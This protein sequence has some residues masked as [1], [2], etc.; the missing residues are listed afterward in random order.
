[1]HFKTLFTLGT[2]ASLAVAA[3][4]STE[5]MTGSNGENTTLV[6]RGDYG[7]GGVVA[8]SQCSGVPGSGGGCMSPFSSNLS[9]KHS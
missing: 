5:I 2:F 8:I 9:R 6:A 1:M 3:P 7:C 4:G